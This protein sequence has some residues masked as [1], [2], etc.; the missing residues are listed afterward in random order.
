MSDISGISTAQNF[1]VNKSKQSDVAA[2]AAITD[3]VTINSAR[4]DND[5]SA[6]FDP[7]SIKT[8]K[9]VNSDNIKT[10]AQ[11]IAVLDQD[12][13]LVNVAKEV[14]NFID[15]NPD[16]PQGWGFKTEGDALAAY[17]DPNS[18]FPKKQAIEDYLKSGVLPAG[19]YTNNNMELNTS[20]YYF[21]D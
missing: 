4:G 17:H 10:Y 8:P 18:N 13:V 21:G 6:D 7:S 16:L 1:D 20:Q 5:K 14:R 19:E 12:V 3:E 2:F 9:D 11:A 15:A